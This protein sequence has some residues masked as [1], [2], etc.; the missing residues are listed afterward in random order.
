[1]QYES[2]K[3]PQIKKIR[4]ENILY[5]FF[6][7]CLKPNYN[8]KFS[9]KKIKGRLFD[10]FSLLSLLIVASFI[11]GFFI[12][13]VM[14]LIGYDMGQNSVVKL[15]EE[16]PALF[17]AFMA[18]IWAPLVEET[19]FRLG[20]RFSPW[21][22]SI[23]LSFV[24]LTIFFVV[25]DYLPLVGEPVKTFLDKS[26]LAMIIFC[27]V[28]IIVFF[29]M[30][31]KFLI[32]KVLGEKKIVKY[33]Q[34]N[35]HI[36]FY[37]VA[38]LFGAIHLL[39]FNNFGK[40]WYVSFLLFLPQLSA[41]F[42]LGFVRMR[43][44]FSW[45]ILTHFLYNSFF[46]LPFLVISQLPQELLNGNSA[47]LSKLPNN[48]LSMFGFFMMFIFLMF[49]SVVIIFFKDVIAYLKFRNQEN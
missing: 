42:V 21:K 13:A 40:F 12:S 43:Y 20:L 16:A 9:E 49:L 48:E 3:V 5:S 28:I 47:V 45:S 24:I 33:Y 44:G 32:I 17:A 46:A 27:A 23:S 30:V 36:I 29:I 38:F 2:S 8:I 11:L 34:H 35:F 1:M 41:S 37:F 15:F 6:S 39:N 7:Y 18:M 19:T 22:L 10:I 4:A 14:N 25:I 31:F 26:S